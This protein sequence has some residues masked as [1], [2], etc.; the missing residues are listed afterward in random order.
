MLFRRLKLR[1]L[2]SF[3]PEGVDLPMEPLTVAI[4]PNGSGKSNLL[5]AISLF[6]A[7]PRDIGEPVQRSGGMRE[8]LWKDTGAEGAATLDATVDVPS[9]RSLRHALTVTDANGR[10]NVVGE[11]I[12]PKNTGSG[13]RASLSYYRPPADPDIAREMAEAGAAADAADAARQL[14]PG[15]WSAPR[16]AAQYSGDAI[17]FAPDFFPADSLLRR[18][19]ASDH[20]GLVALSSRYER[21]RL[22]RDWSFGPGSGLR[23]PGRAHAPA[24]VLDEDAQ[25]LAPVLSQ[26][27]GER[28]MKFAAALG[29]LFDGVANVRCPVAGGAAFLFLEEAGGRSIPATRL[30]D[31]T[32]RYLCLLAVL[33]HPEPPP[34]ICLEEPELGL[35]PD[36][37]PTLADLAVDASQRCQIIVTTHSD[38]FVDALTERP[39]SVVVCEKHDGAT[40]TRRLDPKDLQKWLA[41][42]RLGAL[43][44][45]GELG[46]NRW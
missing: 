12:E 10:L 35:H 29:E 21:I 39:E 2:L 9:I 15:E 13:E 37:L 33:L 43:W 23:Q 32:L 27:S 22:Y 38:I 25:N 41:D 42:Y 8:W 16:I 7:A 34:L 30:S 14:A 6:Q 45:S 18:M 4:G 40:E 11:H 20:P 26:L 31:G 28:K 19:A 5:D 36:L 17:H 24:D 3:G 46:G 44:T 1:G